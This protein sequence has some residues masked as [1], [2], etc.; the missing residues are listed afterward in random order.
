MRRVFLFLLGVFWALAV[1]PLVA[2]AQANS[3]KQTN[4]VS[5]TTGL[6]PN[7]DHNLVNPWG[8]AFFPNQPFWISDNA[9]PT[10]VTTLY[11]QNGKLLGTFTI[12][13][14]HG[15]SNPATPTGLVANI[16]GQGFLVNGQPSNFIFDTEDGTISGWNGAPA[17]TLVVDN[18]NN[19]TAATGAVYKGLALI[20]NNAGAFL[21][22]AN[23]R[24]GK[25]EVYDSN[26][27]NAHLSGDFTDPNPPPIPTGTMSPGWAPFGIHLVGGQV[28]VTYALQDQA[29]HDPIHMS[30]AGFVDLFDL[31]GNLVRRI[32][33]GGNLN[34]PWGAVQAPAGFGA[35][36]GKLLVGNFGDGVMNAFDF[37]SG[38]FLDQMKDAK[39]AVIANA[40]LWDMVFGGG[41]QSGDPNT[42]YITAGLANETHGVFSAITA[43]AAST[44]PGAD[45]SVSVTPATQTI[46]AGQMASFTITIGGLSGFSSAV[47][48]SCSG[49]PLG[50]NCS[51]SP[52]TVTPQSGGTAASTMSIS[53]SSAPYHMAGSTNITGG[54]R[55]AVILPLS[56]LGFLGLVLASMRL[57]SGRRWT[58]AGG[59]AFLLMA[60][61]VAFASGCGGGS[62]NNGMNG[63]QR[64]TATVVV[65][66]TSGSTMHSASVTLTVQ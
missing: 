51:F 54:G 63:T 15:S 57:Q 13:P 40:S 17:A 4:L 43:N 66:G 52:M 62:G 1:R 32:A 64:G 60:G 16:S 24:S 46:A 6:A 8:I 39:G 26:F 3:Y 47:S 53:T 21:L 37:T 31:N 19:P 38:T 55:F 35:F 61:F 28:V 44:P 41:G 14:P 36:G 49:Q 34:A 20:T 48:L 12:P 2:Q 18:S 59:I 7:I 5:D 56:A 9:S 29:Q 58:L 65:T 11:D 27:T 33:T 10:G 23:F 42:M 50:S 30:G 22:A 25:V 45:F